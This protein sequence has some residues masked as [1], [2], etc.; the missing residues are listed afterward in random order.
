MH[1]YHNRAAPIV[2][3]D[4]H[5]LPGRL[6]LHVPGL[7]GNQNIAQKLA[8]QLSG[9]A[10][11]KTG[12]VNPV[13]GRILVLFDP[14]KMNLNK[15]IE[16]ILC[17]SPPS[18]HLDH[19]ATRAEVAAALAAAPGPPV[20]PQRHTPPR[21]IPWHVLETQQVLSVLETGVKSGL[22]PETIQKRLS[23]TGPNELA[24][25]APPSLSALLLE[26]F[27][28]FMS[29]L[30]LAAAGVS[31]LAGKHSD[32]LVIAVIVGLQAIME[33]IQGYRAEKSLAA[34]K[35][36][37]APAASVIRGGVQSK[38]PARL[39]VP[40]DII[41]LEAGD[42]VPA[43]ARLLETCNLMTDE[44]SL[45]GESIPVIKDIT[46]CRQ[47]GLG[48]GDK[49]NMI[50]TGTNITAG[51]GLAV[52]VATGMNTEMGKIARMLKDVKAGPTGLQKQ[53]E[54]TGQKVTKL[55][56]ISVGAIA[57]I[58]FL[59]GKPLLEILR[60]G[61][62]LAVGAIPEGLP[63]V[64]T[65]SLA[66][67]VQRMVRRNAV[68]R[69]LPAVETLGGTTVICTDK[70]GTLTKNEMTVKK[71]Y[72]DHKFYQ[73][74]GEG[75]QPA[76]RFL[77][78][79]QPVKHH[80]APALIKALEAASLCNNA[81]L[82]CK[83][84]HGWTVQGDPTEGALL[85]A[86]AKAGIWWEDLQSKHCRHKEIVFNSTRRM[87]TVICLDPNQ[88]YMAYTKGAPDTVINHCT[89]MFRDNRVVPMDEQTKKKIIL[90]GEIL[91]GKALR[92]LAVAW[93]ELDKEPGLDDQQLEEELI[94]AGLF[95]MADP[96]RPGVREAIHK[97]H[98]AGIGVVM[99]TGDHKKT[100]QAIAQKL[101]ILQNGIT[102]TGE[103]LDRFSDGQL[104]AASNKIRVYA[105][106]SPAQKLR[107][108][109]AL[110]KRGHIV[111]MT[112]DGVNDAP[113][114]K[115]AD[116]GLAMGLAGTDV[117]REAAGMTLSDDNFTTIVAGIEE[118]RTVKKNIAKSTR[119]ILT[120]NSG[121]VVAVFLSAVAGLT[122]PLV[123]SQLLWINLVTESLPAV[124]LV[125][126]PPDKGCM[127]RPPDPPGENIF[128]KGVQKEIIRKGILCGIT[129]FSVYAGSLLAGWTTVKAQTMSFSH[130]V[131]SRVFNIFENG[132][133]TGGGKRQNPYILPAAGLS[134]AMLMLTMY[135]PALRPLFSTVPL[136][137]ADWAVIGLTSGLAGKMES[138]I[139]QVKQT[140]IHK[141]KLLTP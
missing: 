25:Q 119:Y 22:P 103:Q 10:G 21:S 51:R 35:E 9:I 54:I 7:T 47:T 28:G 11:I 88:K 132:K 111:A 137:F 123:P 14:R 53:M 50:F 29:K 24:G 84:N 133:T 80:T 44:A 135:V 33:A 110:K 107:I 13:T 60:T 104:L 34:L 92:V 72:C 68:V 15:L 127:H 109:R 38:I 124:A 8:R 20:T 73:I 81:A 57:A 129:T 5:I 1:S 98:Q 37:S 16:K 94:F 32:A 30:L 112:G 58:G 63:A 59:K 93:R 140:P 45:T 82:Y 19:Q 40:G 130:L 102:I 87:M 17:F 62:S 55:V 101:G 97:C 65:I 116:I 74:T 49:E 64:V 23:K 52:V 126:D 61:V 27:K 83:Q 67:G 39:L 18:R 134:T 43:D 136:G 41:V 36:L 99:I 121:Q 70:T 12:R 4:A 114:I 66:F 71:I 106:T 75:Y 2:I 128:N 31:L 48:T 108:V 100:A 69:K 139:K 76:G 90:A 79:D 56:L 131:M 117:T 96:P 26:P 115:E 91:A 122:T 95:G 89:R 105:R 77:Y 113:A 138:L 3:S 86:A 141:Q 125:A 46:P 6:R 78:R 42:R 85:T 118:G 120:G